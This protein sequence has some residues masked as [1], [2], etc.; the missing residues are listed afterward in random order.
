ML[1]V[2]TRAQL[3]RAM[4]PLGDSTKD[5]VRAEAAARGMVVAD[6][7]DS[8]DV[9]FVPGRGHPGLPGGQLGDA[10]GRS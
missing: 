7:P 5:E 10:P 8:H 4:F 6:K 3:G 9:C 1:A 2:L